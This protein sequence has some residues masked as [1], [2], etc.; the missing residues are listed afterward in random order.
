MMKNTLSLR[1]AFATDKL[2]LCFVLLFA[3]ACGKESTDK[4]TKDT[5]Q[6]DVATLGSINLTA[7]PQLFQLACTPVTIELKD[8]EQK[9]TPVDK[10]VT[11]AII[12]SANIQ[13]FSDSDC[14]NATDE[15]IISNGETQTQFY[16][17]AN[18][19][20][21]GQVTVQDPQDAYTS[22][23]QSF[24]IGINEVMQL[25]IIGPQS[26]VYSTCTAIQV[27]LKNQFSQTLLAKQPI[28]ISLLAK[29][30]N[31]SSEF[32]TIDLK[33]YTDSGCTNMTT[34]TMIDAQTSASTIYVQS[35]KQQ[36]VKLT[37]SDM[38]GNVQPGSTVFSVYDNSNYV[39]GLGGPLQVEISNCTAFQVSY[40][41]SIGQSIPPVSMV[42]LSITDANGAS[43]GIYQDAGCNNAISQV[44]LGGAQFLQTFYVKTTNTVGT[45]QINADNAFGTFVSQSKWVDVVYNGPIQIES[46]RDFTC[47]LFN[48]GDIK[49]W[50]RSRYGELGLGDTQ[51]RGDD[52]NEMGDNLPFIDLGTG[53]TATQITTGRYHTCALLNTGAVKCWGF[54]NHGQL[55]Q[56][57]M[58]KRGDDPSEMGNNLSTIGLGTALT[59][60]QIAAG[61]Y[62][63]C[64]LL[65]TGAVKCW[66]NNQAGQLGLGDAQ[67]R[68]DE[69]NEMGNNLSTIDLGTGLTATQITTGAYHTCALLSNNTIKCWGDNQAGQLGLGDT[70]DRG[71]DVNEMGDNLATINLGTGLT[72]TQIIAG[73]YHTCALLNT[74]EAK[75]WGNNEYGLLGYGNKTED[76]G[77]APNEMGDNLATI[78]LGNGLTVIQMTSGRY[79]NCALL[80]NGEAKCWGFNDR[81]QLGLG[82]TQD[83][84][85]DVNEM[86]DNLATIELGTGLTATQITVGRMHTCALLSNGEAKCWG[87]NEYGQLGLGDAQE[88]GDEPNEMGDFLDSIDL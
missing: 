54:N 42:Q 65:N 86:G 17:R 27:V 16:I 53:L 81:G 79:H 61:N 77:D 35:T 34:T 83:R 72:A 2:L 25:Q 48:T 71:D 13:V 30:T 68:G 64:A 60:T 22:A 73:D 49:C 57:N 75:C 40:G 10:D 47:T 28:N 32:A 36:N 31:N 80:S 67:D 45:I 44:A 4:H 46:K 12:P 50:G 43:A 38:A 76:P 82:D 21:Q 14:L 41:L 52:V 74:G 51:N 18:I 6:Q 5:K 19:G 33:T 87:N 63:T 37:A 88:R 39:M 9:T 3:L 24:T 1:Y 85:D 11:T 58:Q 56:G 62:H 8:A 78:D 55:G 66:G 69:P 15:A 7:D 29:L 59:A 84:G 70:Q 26:L 23:Q 20:T